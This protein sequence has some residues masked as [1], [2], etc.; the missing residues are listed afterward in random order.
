[1]LTA[2]AEVVVHLCGVTRRRWNYVDNKTLVCMQNLVPLSSISIEE[3]QNPKRWEA[4]YLCI[5]Y[6]TILI[7]TSSHSRGA[8]SQVLRG[9]LFGGVSTKDV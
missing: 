5:N 9:Y 1:M 2:V 6:F 7:L 3:D 4:S 8:L